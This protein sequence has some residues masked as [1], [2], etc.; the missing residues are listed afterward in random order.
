MELNVAGKLPGGTLAAGQSVLLSS[1]EIDAVLGANPANLTQGR[2]R[3]T[4]PTSGLRV[5]SLLQTGN[6]APIEY[7]TTGDNNAN[8]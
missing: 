5:Q 4:A 2:I 3:I 1:V 8:N 6:S 7:R